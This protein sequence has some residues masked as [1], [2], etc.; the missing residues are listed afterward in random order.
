MSTVDVSSK[1]VKATKKAMPEI[2]AMQSAAATEQTLD[3][4][5]RSAK[6]THDVMHAMIGK[7]TAKSKMANEEANICYTYLP[8]HEQKQSNRFKVKYNGKIG[9]TYHLTIEL[10]ETLTQED[11]VTIGGI[12][13]F[14]IAAEVNKSDEKLKFRDEGQGR[15]LHLDVVE[16]IKNGSIHGEMYFQELSVGWDTTTSTTSQGQTH[17]KYPFN[18]LTIPNDGKLAKM[19]P[20]LPTGQLRHED[21]SG[22]T[23]GGRKREG[24]KK[25]NST[26]KYH[27]VV[28]PSDKSH[29]KNANDYLNIANERKM[30][31]TQLEAFVIDEKT[32]GEDYD[33]L[34]FK[35][36]I[37]CVEC[38]TGLVAKEYKTKTK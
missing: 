5:V 20:T 13:M 35:Q 11:H 16:F 2:F 22:L 24:S 17:V 15:T 31:K 1:S 33:T 21:F 14:H 29:M 10:L 8:Q 26:R 23:V 7:D 12:T 18:G 9:S 34:T 4:A 32:E 30:T 3:Y 37:N 27:M 36:P 19:L 28:C 25:N 6:H 38:D